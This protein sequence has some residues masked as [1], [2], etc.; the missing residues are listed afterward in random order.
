MG[1]YNCKEKESSDLN[2]NL[3]S[4]ESCDNYFNRIKLM[5]KLRIEKIFSIGISEDMSIEEKIRI[6]NL[7]LSCVLS[8][9]IASTYLLLAWDSLAYRINIFVLLFFILVGW[10]CNYLGFFSFSKHFIFF[11]ASLMLTSLSVCIGPNLGV[12]YYFIV[13]FVSV[14]SHLSQVFLLSAWASIPASCFIITKL[15]H[16]HF[17]AIFPG[18]VLMPYLYLA[19]IVFPFIV[20]Y[21]ILNDFLR[22]HNKYKNDLI[23]NNYDLERQ[24]NDLL[25]SNEIKNKLFSILAHDLRAPFKSVSGFLS[26]LEGDYLTGAEKDMFVKKLNAHLNS[27]SD[28]LD[29]LLVWA[30]KQQKGL[31]TSFEKLDIYDL[32]Q[33]KLVFFQTLAQEKQIHLTYEV[34][35]N[36]NVYADPHQMA[37]ILRNFVANAIKFTNKG[38]E[39]FIYAKKKGDMHW[40]IAVSDTGKGINEA[41]IALIFDSKQQFTTVGTAKEKGTGL[42]LPLCKEFIENHG[43]NLAISSREGEGSTFSFCLKVYI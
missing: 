26:L 10:F 27:S 38:G 21:I 2:F 34:E 20:T 7:N 19:N 33:E 30:T 3:V 5:I 6:R 16:I 18:P 39:I 31:K 29:N 41:Q 14:M 11:T 9:I 4:I 35:P 13:L 25:S 28:M 15:S 36:T 43:A 32:L 17:G 8:I 12:E 37:F 1:I 24:K 40:E 23:Q 22:E 42:G